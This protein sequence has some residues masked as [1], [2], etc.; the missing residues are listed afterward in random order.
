MTSPETTPTTEAALEQLTTLDT[1]TTSKSPLQ[2][3]ASPPTTAALV[4]GILKANGNHRSSDD[5]DDDQ[6]N[7]KVA[8]LEEELQRA[9]EERE[10]YASQYRTLLSRIEKMKTSLGTKLKLDAVRAFLVHIFC[11]A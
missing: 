6:E 11:L 9:K 4:N 8:R 1:A 5:D 7:D 2:S 3:P 10:N